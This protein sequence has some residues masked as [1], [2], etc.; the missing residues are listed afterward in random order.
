MIRLILVATAVA[1]LSCP[2][3]LHAQAPGGFGRAVDGDTLMVGEQKVR[4]FGIDAPELDQSCTREGQTWACGAD[5][6]DQLAKLVNGRPV[7]CQSMGTDQYGRVV[8]RCVAGTTDLNRTMVANGY[9]VAYRQYSQDYVSTE[10]AAHAAKRGIWAGS[11]EMPDQYRHASQ[12]PSW[13]NKSS[14][15]RPSIRSS[16]RAGRAQ[17]NCNIKGNR[18]RK[19]QWIYHLP[20]MPYYDQTRPEEIFCTEAEAQAAGYRRAIVR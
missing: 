3:T 16:T 13:A 5:A 2:T 14:G 4:L 20:G 6:A 9:A 12:G 7:Y 18:N 1:V 19:G 10:A 8:G 11:F 15:G 17:D